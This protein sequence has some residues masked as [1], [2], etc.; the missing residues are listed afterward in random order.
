M[1]EPNRTPVDIYGNPLNGDH[2]IN[3]CF[4]DC[5]CDGERLCTAKNGAS[6]VAC[7]IN[8]ERRSPAKVRQRPGCGPL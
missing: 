3:C 4:P 6:G 2:I 5:G 1:S 7:E 8:V